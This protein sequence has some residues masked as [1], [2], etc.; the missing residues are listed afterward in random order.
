[1]I[2]HVGNRGR[3]S[4]NPKVRIDR[5]R[6]RRADSG[7]DVLRLMPGLLKRNVVRHHLLLLEGMVGG[8]TIRNAGRREVRRLGVV[9]SELIAALDRW[10]LTRTALVGLCSGLLCSLG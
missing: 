1:M 7:A 8:Q 10:W 2:P 4:R 5:L 3:L 6:S 9:A